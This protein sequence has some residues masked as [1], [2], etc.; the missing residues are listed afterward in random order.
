[1]KLQRICLLGLGEVGFTL[2]QDLLAST[3]LTLQLWDKQFGVA[4]S[5]A[6][7]HWAQLAESDRVCRADSAAE[8]A[9]QCQV[10]FSAVTADQALRAAESILPGLS[11]EHS[12]ELQQPWF[13]DLNSVS[14]VTKQQIEQKVSPTGSR[15]VEAA[16]MSP[17]G[18]QGIASP[19][20]LAGPHA[21]DF[22]PLGQTLGFRAMRAVSGQSG[23]AAATKMCRSVIIK[24]VEALL[25]E[26][27]LTARHY[28]VEDSVLES[29]NNLVPHPDWSEH[30]CYLIS[31]SLLHGTRRAEEM[32]EAARAVSEAGHIPWMSEAC[33][34]RQEWAA[35]FKSP[36][37]E[38]TLGTLLDG[39]NSQVKLNY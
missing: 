23:V 38:H 4:G 30:A 22:E 15:F 7:H 10:V 33:M 16:V 9:V 3:Q 36:S 26:S 37:G 39:I 5:V 29:L 19:M 21:R 11:S 6:D 17:I 25:T 28:G 2:A 12:P 18:P 1:M 27:L 20:F 13:V 31:R 24:G 34:K 35:Q 32:R 8:A 14:P